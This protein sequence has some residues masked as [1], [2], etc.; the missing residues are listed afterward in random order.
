M[1]PRVSPGANGM[2]ELEIDLR[3]DVIR[4]PF[5]GSSLTSVSDDLDNRFARF[6]YSI[7]S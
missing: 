1:K 5:A 7:T 6:C 3:F 2:T 4:K